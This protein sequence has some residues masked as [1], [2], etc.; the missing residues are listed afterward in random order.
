MKLNVKKLIGF[1]IK[2]KDGEFGKVHDFYF[3]DRNYVIR[4]LVADTSPWL[5]DRL[6]LISPVAITKVDLE[7]LSIEVN[8]DREQVVNSPPISHDMPV[9]R[10]KELEL[11]QYYGW[12]DYWQP[13]EVNL[14]E[15]A[16]L[17]TRFMAEKRAHKKDQKES[18]TN[19]YLRS[20]LEIL[21]YK[22]KAKRGSAGSVFDYLTEESD[23]VI[24]Y[25]VIK[26]GFWGRK[27]LLATNW[28]EDIDWAQQHFKVNIAR[29]LIRNSERFD[30]ADLP[31]S[32][33]EK[34]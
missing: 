10:S 16:V 31:F 2:A 11:L 33:N 4:Y 19:P 32:K 27:V 34:Q 12:P 22:I 24:R 21:G 9:S 13:M 15:T 14:P 29:K 8:L 23:W 28:I 17:I 6:V 7:S 25:F 30:Y 1:N 26:T 18:P 5:P 3:D 20:T